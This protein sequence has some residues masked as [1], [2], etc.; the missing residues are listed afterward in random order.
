[1]KSKLFKVFE[2]VFWCL[3][4][5]LIVSFVVFYIIDKDNCLATVE[6]AIELVNQP[7]PVVGVTT[8]AVLIFLWKVII[9][10][11]YGKSKL[12][13]YEKAK[14]EIIS[15]KEKF[16]EDAN[17]KI[18]LLEQQNKDL[19]NK[20]SYVCSLSTNKKIK[21]YGKELDTYGKE[22]TNIDTEKE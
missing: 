2:I 13:Q 6:Y 14:Q 4:A 11:N 7:L 20:L 22:T 15:E 16:I 10:T 21:D 12:A 8:L 18:S 5:S 19:E 17:S 3:L 1:M 9:T